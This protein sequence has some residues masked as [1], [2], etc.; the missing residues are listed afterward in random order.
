MHANLR[1][2]LLGTLFAGGLLALGTTVASAADTSGADGTASG[3]QVVAPVTAPVTLGA[4]SLGVLG[5]SEAAVGGAAAV[6]EPSTAALAIDPPAIVSP[7]V[8]PGSE[9]A[10]SGSAAV[11]SE[12]AGFGSAAVGSEAAGSGSAA[13]GS[14]A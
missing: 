3:T 4:T 9:A 5:D 2:G 8:A 14:E 7:V 6:A 10:G 11:G 13:V 1:R 12:A